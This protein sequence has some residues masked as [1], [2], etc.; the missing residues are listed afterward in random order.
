MSLIDKVLKERY[1]LTE[2]IAEGGMAS[3]Y[4][5]TDLLLHRTIAVKILKENLA[6]D[7]EGVERFYREARSSAK[8]SH[9]N[10]VNIYD[11]GQEGQ[12]YFI[13][14]EYLPGGTLDKQISSKTPLSVE[15]VIRIGIEI[16]EALDYAHT[17]GVIHRDIKAQNIML[18]EEKTI[19]VVDFG[20]AR[21]MDTGTMT[22]PG[23][24]MG[25]VYYFA[26]EQAEGRE[27][28]VLLI[29]TLQVYCS[30]I[31]PQVIIL[32]MERMPYQ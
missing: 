8:L 16:T 27:C 19:K 15:E 24:V 1:K 31:L 32:L 6:L 3:V 5:G 20:I 23:T 12:I 17:K 25:S 26:P 22:K 29:Y 28:R 4:K 11:I 21:V 7:K 18:T 9:P 13:V 10:I 14:M 30:I 2:L